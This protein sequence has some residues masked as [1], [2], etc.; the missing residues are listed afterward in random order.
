M[1]VL[2]VTRG[3]FMLYGFYH[4]KER[5]RETQRENDVMLTPEIHRPIHQTQNRT[6]SLVKDFMNWQRCKKPI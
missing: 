1:N 5:E 2:N 6:T 3:K 4:N